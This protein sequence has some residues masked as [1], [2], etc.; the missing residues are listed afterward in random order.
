MGVPKL[1]KSFGPYFHSRGT[2]SISGWTE[3]P[4]AHMCTAKNKV[5]MA[6]FTTGFFQV[7]KDPAHTVETAYHWND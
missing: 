4:Y 2:S 3:I 7:E 6:N 5:K 1:I